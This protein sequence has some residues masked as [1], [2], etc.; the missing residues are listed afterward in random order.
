MNINELLITK[1]DYLYCIDIFPIETKAKI[2]QLLEDRYIWK[3]K[4]VLSS[5]TDA[6]IDD[7]HRT[8][9]LNNDLIQQEYIEDENALLFNIGF[10][11]SEAESIVND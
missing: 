2:K 5:S 7:T 1:E 8:I 11:V 10:S 9:T 3:S 4:S 6:I